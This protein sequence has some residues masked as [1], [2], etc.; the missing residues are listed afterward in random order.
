MAQV[1]RLEDQHLPGNMNCML[2]FSSADGAYVQNAK[3]KAFGHAWEVV[4]TESHAREYRAMYPRQRAVGRFFL[5][6]ELN[7]Y[8]EFEQIMQ[9]F[10]S[11]VAVLGQQFDGKPTQRPTMLV[12]MAVRGFSRSGVPIKGMSLGDHVGSMVF[13]P[14]VIFESAHDPQDPTILTAADASQ[15]DTK[16]TEADVKNFFYPFSAASYDTNVKP[17]TVYDFTPAGSSNF[18]GKVGGSIA[19]QG[20]TAGGSVESILDG[21]ERPMG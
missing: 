8:R 7:G 2:S 21:L 3:V 19:E 1:E 20:A 9:F 14:T 4:A 11:Y 17:E 5:T 12:Q 18:F 6:F 16:G 10:R 13:N 15:V